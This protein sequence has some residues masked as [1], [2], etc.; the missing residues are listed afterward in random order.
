MSTAN[1]FTPV[2]NGSVA[3]SKPVKGEKT[4]GAARAIRRSVQK[5]A[6]KGAR[7]RYF[8]AG[9]RNGSDGALP[10]VAFGVFPNV[11]PSNTR[12]ELALTIYNAAAAEHGLIVG[13]CWFI[14]G[15]ALAIGYSVLVYRR[16]AGKVAERA[17][18]E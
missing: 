12:P 9:E 10:V 18:E 1:T 4:N 5:K 15:M 17:L 8:L 11:L 6:A 14:P 3:E 13:L 16:F 7:E 2:V